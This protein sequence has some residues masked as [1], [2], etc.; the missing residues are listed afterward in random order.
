M[1]FHIIQPAVYKDKKALVEF[2]EQT[3]KWSDYNPPMWDKW[4]N[5]TGSQLL[6]TTDNGQE[7]AVAHVTMVAPSEAWL[8]SLRVAPSH[9]GRGIAVELIRHS[10]EVSKKH[11]A[12][13]V[14]G[15]ILNTSKAIHRIG[16]KLGFHKAA[17]FCLNWAPKIQG[18][19]S[20]LFLPLPEHLKV[21]WAF[22]QGSSIYSTVKGLYSTEW[23]YHKLTLN[24]L[25]NHLGKGEILILEEGKEINAL[26]IWGM[27]HQGRQRV[28]GYIDGSIDTMNELALALRTHFKNEFPHEINITLPDLPPLRNIFISSGYQPY[29]DK[30]FCI[31]ERYL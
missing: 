12:I 6:I 5:N 1:K 26:A 8:Q 31:F 11:G 22:V 27:A 24:K 3:A 21:L 15:A 29:Y 2:L 4:I 19:C 25:R 20:K 28:I 9:R 10:I 18:S 13:V 7:V 23:K 17:F 16:K 14:R 30:P